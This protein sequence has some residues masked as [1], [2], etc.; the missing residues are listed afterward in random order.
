[1]IDQERFHRLTEVMDEMKAIDHLHRLG[2]PPANAVVVQVTAV[3]TDHP[4]EI[5]QSW[6][7]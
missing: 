5:Q 6:F 3:A 2:C 7:T 4:I 1:V